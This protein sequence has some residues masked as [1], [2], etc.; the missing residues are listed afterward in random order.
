MSLSTGVSYYRPRLA[1]SDP[2]Q[3]AP[4]DLYCSSNGLPKLDVCGPVH[5]G[6]MYDDHHG[7][8][9][10]FTA[11]AS[12]PS[13]T[14]D[15]RCSPSVHGYDYEPT[16]RYTRPAVTTGQL[17]V[18]YGQGF[19][20]VHSHSTPVNH[21]GTSS[22]SALQSGFAIYPWMRSVTAGTTVLDVSMLIDTCSI[23]IV[24][25]DN[26]TNVSYL[27]YRQGNGLAIHRSR[28]QVLAGHH[29]VVANWASY[30][31]LCASVTK[32]YSLI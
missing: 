9:V 15:V 5:S 17:E 3:F 12:F 1:T 21:A 23:S 11:G 20:R 24:T 29:Y 14:F 28:I 8:S 16:P 22:Q 26:V 31:H 27:R 25:L 10:N 13:T 7:R 19:A 2:F 18:S 32:Q 6:I 30:L 4:A